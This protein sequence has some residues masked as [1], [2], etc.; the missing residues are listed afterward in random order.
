MEISLKLYELSERSM[1]KRYLAYKVKESLIVNK[2]REN[3]GLTPLFPKKLVK[4]DT[5]GEIYS[6]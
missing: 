3:S 1:L 4:K 2:P 5:P 6:I